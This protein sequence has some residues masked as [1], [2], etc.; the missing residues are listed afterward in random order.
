MFT[1]KFQKMEGKHVRLY[2]LTFS[3]MPTALLRFAKVSKELL[4]K[5]IIN[6]VTHSSPRHHWTNVVKTKKKKKK[7][8]LKVL[9]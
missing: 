9:L 6:T 7:K 5:K 2:L 1:N 8:R 3:Q 4:E